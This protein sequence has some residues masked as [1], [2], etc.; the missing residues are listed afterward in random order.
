MI[1]ST[2][3]EELINLKRVSLHILYADFTKY[4][5]SVKKSLYSLLSWI[6][7]PAH[8]LKHPLP[9]PQRTQMFVAAYVTSGTGDRWRY[10]KYGKNLILSPIFSCPQSAC[11]NVL[12]TFKTR[13]PRPRPSATFFLKSP[14]FASTLPIETLLALQRNKEVQV[15]YVSASSCRLPACCYCTEHWDWGVR[16]PLV[17]RSTSQLAV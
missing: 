16:A 10:S 9:G 1:H 7:L 6:I 8:R 15:S 17:P 3:S 11:S 4:M 14:R 12:Q 2:I 5:K 13:S